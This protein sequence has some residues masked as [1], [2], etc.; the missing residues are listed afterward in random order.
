MPRLTK[1]A[2]RI[3]A[4][5]AEEMLE[6]NGNPCDTFEGVLNRRD[7]SALRTLVAL[8]QRFVERRGAAPRTKGWLARPRG[9]A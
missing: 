8:G 6:R 7:V 9:G 5:R 3:A 2:V 4:T 1:K